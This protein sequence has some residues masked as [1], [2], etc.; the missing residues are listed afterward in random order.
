MEHSGK[1][2]ENV[3]VMN[4]IKDVVII[5]YEKA[6]TSRIPTNKGSSTRESDNT[7]E[8]SVSFDPESRKR[9]IQQAE[10]KKDATVI[11]QEILRAFR[12]ELIAGKIKIENDN[13]PMEEKQEELARIEKALIN[14]S[15]L[16]P[17]YLKPS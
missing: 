7:Q 13:R 4:L 14:I 15:H 17:H 11:A 8:S 12:K 3:E 16:T 6:N 9:N 5:N 10:V 1:R 2:Y